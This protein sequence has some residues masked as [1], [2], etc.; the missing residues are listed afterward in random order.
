MPGEG[1]DLFLFFL[2]NQK[3]FLLVNHFA[4]LGLMI[5][6]RVGFVVEVLGAGLSG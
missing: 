1:P 2:A 4:G 6:L 5:C 3:C